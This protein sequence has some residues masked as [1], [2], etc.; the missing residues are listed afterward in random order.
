MS[1]SQ[2]AMNAFLTNQLT[3]LKILLFK[4]KNKQSH[5]RLLCCFMKL[6][7]MMQFSW[8]LRL[9][10]TVILTTPI[11][12]QSYFMIIIFSNGFRFPFSLLSRE[13]TLRKNREKDVANNK[14]RRLV[15][16]NASYPPQHNSYLEPENF[17]QFTI[18]HGNHS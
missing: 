5:S 13:I 7:V 18:E 6:L 15:W 1:K 10:P 16:A 17:K 8:V 11:P 2:D 12:T 4:R 3:K 9:T 14:C